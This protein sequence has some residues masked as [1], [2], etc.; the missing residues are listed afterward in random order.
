MLNITNNPALKLPLYAAFAVITFSTDSTPAL[1]TTVSAS[2][3]GNSLTLPSTTGI[4]AGDF[5]V[6]ETGNSAGTG[7]WITTVIGVTNATVLGVAQPGVRSTVTNAV[8]NRFER[9][10]TR[11]RAK[12]VT[13]TNLTNGDVHV[14]DTTLLPNQAYRTS[15]GVTTTIT[16]GILNLSNCICIHPNLLPVSSN[17]S[18]KCDY[19]YHI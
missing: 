18:L 6:T 19:D 2:A 17:F 3:N 4:V 8:L 10:E 14:W 9:I 7:P 12:K 15:G 5:V 11:F 16:D 1:Q 13:L